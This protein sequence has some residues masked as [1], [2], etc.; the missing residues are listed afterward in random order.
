V[1]AKIGQ[2]A[3]ELA[4]SRASVYYVPTPVSEADLALMRRIDELHL[5]L[6]FTVSPTLAEREAE[7]P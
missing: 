5:E 2:Q 3:L 1:H 6:P 4:L 7:T